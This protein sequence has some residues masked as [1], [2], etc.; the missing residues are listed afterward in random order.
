MKNQEVVVKTA[1][2][3]LEIA[4]RE[5]AAQLKQETAVDAAHAISISPSGRISERFTMTFGDVCGRGKYAWT[6]ETAESPESLLLQMSARVVSAKNDREQTIEK[7]R[8]SAGE[9][10]LS[11]VEIGKEG[12]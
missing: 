6:H 1:M 11:L 4:A 12:A 3:R 7:L 5:I 10:G 2:E 8:K 9:L